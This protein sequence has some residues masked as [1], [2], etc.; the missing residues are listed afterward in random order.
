MFDICLLVIIMEL[1]DLSK[2]STQYEL[3]HAALT[4]MCRIQVP[5]MSSTMAFI[6]WWDQEVS[7]AVRHHSLNKK[8]TSVN[9]V[10][11]YSVINN[12]ED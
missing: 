5:I 3:I 11:N 1:S 7:I 6:V 8:R 9:E 10:L 2:E 4:N 12:R